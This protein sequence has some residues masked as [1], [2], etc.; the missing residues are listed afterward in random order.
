ME[1]KHYEKLDETVVHHQCDNGLDVYCVLKPGFNK[2]FVSYTTKYGAMDDYF[3]VNN[4]EVRVPDGVAHF[5]EHKMFEKEDGD[6]FQHFG[7][8]GANA[9]AFTS[10][11]RTSYLFST[12]TELYSNLKILMDMVEQP[13]FTAETVEKEVGIIGEELKMY[14]DDPDYRSYME[15]L[16]SMYQDSPLRTDILGSHES[17]SQI[18][19][20]HLYMCHETFYHPSNMVLIIVGDVDHE[21]VIDYIDNH[22]KARGLDNNHTIERILHTEQRQIVK[23]YTELHLDVSETKVKVGYKGESLD[24]SPRDRMK[25]DLSMML[26]LDLVFGE[27]SPHFYQLQDDGLIDDSFGFYHSEEINDSYTMFAVNSDDPEAFVQALDQVIETVKGAP[28][29]TEDKLTLKK[30]EVIGDYLSSLNSPEYVSYQY[31]KYY[32]DG[33]NLYDL[34]E[35]VDE[36]SVDEI[37]T[38]FKS[39]LDK[40]YQSVSV[41][42][43]NV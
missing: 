5:L 41:V 19:H 17:I 14:L 29:F 23:P 15:L 3:I 20:E 31:T 35:V 6:V 8:N 27:Q 4:E 24:M 12:T 34:L 42:K 9:N 39:M 30:R 13:Y 7:K 32:L 16:K 21:A 36:I 1:I 22:Q 37:D 40:Q 38:L 10:H 25:K 2:K 26:A 28:F 33:V 18:T 43:P 11:D